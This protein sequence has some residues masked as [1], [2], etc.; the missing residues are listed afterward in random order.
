MRTGPHKNDDF[1]DIISAAR[2]IYNNMVS[3]KEWNKVNPTNAK[4]LALTSKL[5]K[6][7]K[8][9]VVLAA[10]ANPSD[11]QNNG[12]NKYNGNT[13]GQQSG[14]PAGSTEIAPGGLEK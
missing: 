10:A 3:A 9:K 8:Q 1:S 4:F 12:N 11:N 5:K 6:L 2:T 13:N 7:K 14:K